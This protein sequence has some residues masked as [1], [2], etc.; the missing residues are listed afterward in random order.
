MYHSQNTN[1]YQVRFLTLYFLV[2][3]VDNLSKMRS[4]IS[5]D[6]LDIRKVILKEI[7]EKVKLNYHETLSCMQRV[8]GSQVR[9]SKE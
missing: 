1:V 7:L 6:T 5:L 3:Y 2:L 9:V 8:Q 4:S